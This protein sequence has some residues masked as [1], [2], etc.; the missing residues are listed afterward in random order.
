MTFLN[1][2]VSQEQRSLP[3][4]REKISIGLKRHQENIQIKRLQISYCLIL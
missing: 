1:M 2:G 4:I 3:L